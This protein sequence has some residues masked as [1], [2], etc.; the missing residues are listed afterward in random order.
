MNLIVLSLLAGCQTVLIHE[1]VV[2]YKTNDTTTTRARWMVTMVIDLNL[3]DL[4]INKIHRDIQNAAGV[5]KAIVEYY[6]APKKQ[7]IMT[8]RVSGTPEGHGYVCGTVASTV[9]VQQW[10]RQ[11]D[12][13]VIPEVKYHYNTERHVNH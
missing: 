7:Q 3:F 9:Y 1:N 12:S 8:A 2:F 13:Q 11:R 5:V 10:N 4:F 6:E